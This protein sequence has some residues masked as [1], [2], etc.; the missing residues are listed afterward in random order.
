[1]KY[2]KNIGLSMGIIVV[3]LLVITF[4]FSTL[5]YFKLISSTTLS[6][7]KIIVPIISLLIGGIIIGRKSDKKGWL[8][9]LKLGLIFLILL[10]LFN[11][12]GLEAKI[13]LKNTIYYSI[14]IISSILGS[15]IGINLAP[16]EE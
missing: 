5:Y 14:I 8:E 16:K 10:I 9:G 12:L 13:E 1:M 4:L 7:L 6:I 15:M 11:I 3:S 2:L